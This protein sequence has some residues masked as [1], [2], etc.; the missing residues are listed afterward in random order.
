MRFSGN[1]HRKDITFSITESASLPL[2]FHTCHNRMTPN[3]SYGLKPERNSTQD[4]S[5]PTCKP[6]NPSET[7][8][9][10]IGN[11]LQ[12][13]LQIC[14]GFPF[15]CKQ[16]CNGFPSVFAFRFH[17]FPSY[18]ELIPTMMVCRSSSPIS[19]PQ[20]NPQSSPR[21]SPRSSPGSIL[22]TT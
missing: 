22:D 15:V 16:I 3:C 19:S 13:C 5:S 21:S 6:A 20:P 18:V 11:P 7:H 14:N 2:H 8:R 4:L 10:P 12:I 1:R 9:K 17:F